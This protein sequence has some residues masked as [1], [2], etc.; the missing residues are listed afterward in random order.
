MRIPYTFI[1]ER[2]RESVRAALWLYLLCKSPIETSDQDIDN[3]VAQALDMVDECHKTY[4]EIIAGKQK[5]Q[6]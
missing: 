4:M 6:P 1:E 2:K 3:M 5:T